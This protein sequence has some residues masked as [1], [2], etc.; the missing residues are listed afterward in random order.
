VARKPSKTTLN[1]ALDRLV[2]I[3]VRE[4]N[5]HKCERCGLPANQVHHVL[6]RRYRRLRWDK[7]NL[8]SICP[9]HHMGAHHSP[10]EFLDWFRRARPED[11]DFIRNP[12]SSKPINRS[13]SDLE[14]LR[15]QLREVA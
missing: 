7:R 8:V 12:E 4:A 6:S 9:R 2:S 11:Y 3:Q 1:N 13:V 15:D 14:T 5:D 10:I